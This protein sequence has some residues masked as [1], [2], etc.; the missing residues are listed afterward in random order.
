M[1]KG[2]LSVM[3]MESDVSRSFACSCVRVM[4]VKDLSS[5]VALHSIPAAIVRRHNH[6][7]E[8]E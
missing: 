1:F 6:L 5:N 8:D 3:G 4:Y 7:A 2:A